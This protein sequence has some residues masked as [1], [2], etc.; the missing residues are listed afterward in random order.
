M[1]TQLQ[2][3]PPAA[4]PDQ[5]RART[6]TN[7]LLSLSPT[8]TRA[9][10]APN[11]PKPTFQQVN[12]VEPTRVSRRAAQLARLWRKIPLDKRSLVKVLLVLVYA[13]M[14]V[15]QIDNKHNLI[16]APT[17][18]D[19]PESSSSSS[20]T[21]CCGGGAAAADQLSDERQPPGES[22]LLA[23]LDCVWTSA[24]ACSAGSAAATETRSLAARLI[25][26]IGHLFGSI[27]ST[28]TRLAAAALALLWSA[29]RVGPAL[30]PLWLAR[31]RSPLI[32]RLAQSMLVHVYYIMH[33]SVAR[34]NDNDDRM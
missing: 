26:L 28:A 14:L 3:G 13:Q 19:S 10:P 15:Q 32:Q 34:P 20:A 4:R 8:P 27:S 25:A 33:L 29:L 31:W 12:R 2:M 1:R 6:Q 23:W 16:D 22:A 9:R 11:G 5:S 18:A 7:L 21:R 30:V 24:R 17:R